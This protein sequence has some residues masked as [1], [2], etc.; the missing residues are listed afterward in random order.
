VLDALVTQFPIDLAKLEQALPMLWARWDISG[1]GHVT[2][3]EFVHP[4]RGL[5][6]FVRT[7]LLKR[8]PP[9]PPAGANAAV[10]FAFFD[11]NQTG[12]LTRSQLLRALVKSS[13][14]LDSATVIDTLEPLGLLPH[15]ANGAADADA[16]DEFVTLDEFVRI[17]AVLM[18]VLTQHAAISDAS[19]GALTA[20]SASANA[21]AGE[22]RARENGGSGGSPSG[23]RMLW[24][25]DAKGVRRLV[26]NP[27][28]VPPATHQPR[29]RR[30]G[31]WL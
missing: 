20:S 31:Y 22:E 29:E 28:Y 6:R 30:A 27:H 23:Y 12:R 9:E 17:D 4:E 24:A 7:K 3:D 10:W 5:L 11:D 1:S 8:P 18:N 26:R 19:D 13:E 14:R 15:D 16:D 25:T 2:R 21:S